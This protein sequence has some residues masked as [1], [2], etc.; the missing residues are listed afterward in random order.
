MEKAEI[1]RDVK[2]VLKANHIHVDFYDE[3]I[4]SRHLLT[5]VRFI[6]IILDIEEILQMQFPTRDVSLSKLCSIRKIADFIQSDRGANRVDAVL[7]AAEQGSVYYKKFITEVK[8]ENPYVSGEV[9][10]RRLPVLRPEDIIQNRQIIIKREYCFT[11]KKMLFSYPILQKEVKTFSVYRSR[12]EVVCSEIAVWR[13]RRQWYHLSPF[14]KGCLLER[15]EEIPHQNDIFK[16]YRMTLLWQNIDSVNYETWHQKMRGF[17]PDWIQASLEPLIGY[18][19]Y[20][21][22]NGILPLS[23]VRYVELI[24]VSPSPLEK[25]QIEEFFSCKVSF[26]YE[27]SGFGSVAL[28]CPEGNLHLLSE[29]VYVEESRDGCLILTSLINS[30]F[31]LLRYETKDKGKLV[32][33]D[34]PGRCREPLLDLLFSIK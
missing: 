20:C 4:A 22:R 9:L 24:N 25:M 19:N 6:Q 7:R 31:P 34:C 14:A 17:Q 10:L 12:D 8:K 27:Y 16:D 30:V 11:K 21:K 32:R 2:K 23:S 13:K 29:A 3:N 28:S 26:L 5:P 18:I 1:Y 15:E 33:S